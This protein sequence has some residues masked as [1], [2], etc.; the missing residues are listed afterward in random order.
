M[1]DLVRLRDEIWHVES[2]TVTGERTLLHLRSQA[3]G[4]K[5]IAL[6]PP[7][8]VEF[9][10]GLPPVLDRRAMSPFG[11]WQLRHEMIHLTTRSAGL[12]AVHAGRVQLEPYQLLPVTRLLA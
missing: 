8:L 5:L 3:T 1:N 9:V 6:C 11:T 7:D 4:A 12:A 10:P 2:E